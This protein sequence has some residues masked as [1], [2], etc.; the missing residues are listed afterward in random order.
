MFITYIVVVL[1]LII[2]Y[3]CNMAL[4][5]SGKCL[6]PLTSN[7]KMRICFLYHICTLLEFSILDKFNMTLGYLC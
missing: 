3:S 1:Y 7:M 6:L 2:S 5:I 4:D